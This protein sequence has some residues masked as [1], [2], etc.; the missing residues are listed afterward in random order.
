MK[1]KFDTDPNGH[2]ISAEALKP[3]VDGLVESLENVLCDASVVGAKTA[4]LARVKKVFNTKSAALTT[5]EVLDGLFGLQGLAKDRLSRPV[6]KKVADVCD[7]FYGKVYR[8]IVDQK[9]QVTLVTVETLAAAIPEGTLFETLRVRHLGESLAGE[10]RK[11]S[12]RCA[13][14][15]ER[16]LPNLICADKNLQQIQALVESIQKKIAA[17]ESVSSNQDVAKAVDAFYRGILQDAKRVPVNRNTVVSPS[18]LAR[19]LTVVPAGVARG[20]SP[21]VPTAKPKGG[22]IV[23]RVMT[24]AIL[25]RATQHEITA[26]ELAKQRAL[27]VTAASVPKSPSPT[28]QTL[29]RVHVGQ[30]GRGISV[31]VSTTAGT[32]TRVTVDFRCPEEE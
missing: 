18:D 25:T 26:A 30:R 3:D 20:V 21:Q 28:Q 10:I 12:P 5:D 22:G 16:I 31:T 4:I 17:Y 29:V 23:P 8:T 1:K 9:K 32:D 2:S 27:A 15:I 13:N 24:Q 6:A 7:E 11:F 14:D 19:Y